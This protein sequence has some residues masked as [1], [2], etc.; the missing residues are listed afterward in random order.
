MLVFFCIFSFI[1][2]KC[3]LLSIKNVKSCY[4]FYFSFF[5]GY[6]IKLILGRVY[7]DLKFKGT[8]FY[9]VEFKVVRF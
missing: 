1:Y 3:I 7:F 4:N 2:V 6:L 9:D 8:V 5:F